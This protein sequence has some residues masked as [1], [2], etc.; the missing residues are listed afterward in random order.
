MMNLVKIGDKTYV[1]K[2][3]VNIGIYVFNDNEVCLIDT[4]IKDMYY[5]SIEKALSDKDWKL[6]YIINTHGHADH[7]GENHYLQEK[8]N[9][10]IFTS[11]YESSFVKNPILGNYVMYGSKPILDMQ[12]YLMSAEESVCEDVE[13]L[14]I[15]GLE[16][17][18]LFGHSIGHI[19]VLTSDEVLFCGDSYAS[20]DIL[21]KYPIQYTYDV[22]G[23]LETLG[24]LKN[25][26]YKYYVPSHGEIEENC[27]STIDFNIENVQ[28]IE[29]E[30]LMIIKNEISYE[31]LLKNIFEKHH[32][33]MSIMQYYLIG[34]T[35]KA[36]LTKLYEDKKIKF[37]FKNNVMSIELI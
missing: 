23:Y 24:F 10:K 20:K 26:N 15:P 8:Y 30:I 5:E 22:K 16:I 11:K 13:N 35:V 18:P 25:S 33:S 31:N 6:K 4:G 21:K 27:K 28:T 9:C 36:Y 2:G 14:N 32:I 37:N 7:I 19:G 17:V 3:N 34:S 1:L 12:N 29:N